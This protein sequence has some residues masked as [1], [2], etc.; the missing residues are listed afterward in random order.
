MA[1]TKAVLPPETEVKAA[2]LAV[3]LTAKEK[4]NQKEVKA[5][6]EMTSKAKLRSGVKATTL[7]ETKATAET[8][9]KAV[10]L[11]VNQAAKDKTNQQEVKSTSGMKS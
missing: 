2:P 11:I 1:G 10:P 7:V 9:V 3:L 8:E 5:T 4:T 6:T